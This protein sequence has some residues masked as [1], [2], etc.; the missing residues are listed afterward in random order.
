[1]PAVVTDAG[2]SGE[3][4]ISGKTGFV[5][6]KQNHVALSRAIE[7]MLNLPA[8][9]RAQFAADARLRATQ[10]FAIEKIVSQWEA[11]YETCLRQSSQPDA[12]KTPAS[13]PTAAHSFRTQS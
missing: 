5:V 13:R 8:P 10:E 2:G 4:V 6:P 1:L 3:V 7:Q 9:R 12:S 11:L